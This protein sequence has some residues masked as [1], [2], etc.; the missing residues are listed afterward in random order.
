MTITEGQVT[1][2]TNDLRSVIQGDRELAF[3]YLH[4]Q[5]QYSISA[6][7][8]KAQLL[9]GGRGIGLTAYHF[10]LQSRNL[11]LLIHRWGQSLQHMREPLDALVQRGF[12]ELFASVPDAHPSVLLDALL[13]ASGQDSQ[14]VPK[15]HSL[16]AIL[17]EH[18]ES[19]QKV[20]IGLV[21][22]GNTDEAPKSALLSHFTEEVTSR[23][24]LITDFL[25]REIPVHLSVLSAVDR[26]Q[27]MTKTPPSQRYEL[28]MSR[29][30][31]WGTD[32]D[33][34]MHIG[35]VRL[36]DLGRMYKDLG[37]AFFE[38]NVRAGLAEDEAPNRAIT[39]A[40]RSIIVDQKTDPRV[41]AFNHNGVTLSVESLKPIENGFEIVNPRLL[42][43]AQTVSTFGRF[44]EKAGV[45]LSNAQLTD[46][47]VLAKII[48]SPDDRFTA[49]VTINNNRQNPVMPWDLRANDPIQLAIQDWLRDTLG[50][51]YERQANSFEG[52]S[53]LSDEQRGSLGIIASKPISL[54]KLAS[55][56]LAVDGRVDKMGR[57]KEVF[58]DDSIYL[59]VFRPDRLE[60]DARAVVYCYKI[61]KCIAKLLKQLNPDG[62][63][64]RYAFLYRGRNLVWALL[65]QAFLN[66]TKNLADNMAFYGDELVI[67]K[68]L[69]DKLARLAKDKV[70]PILDRLVDQDGYRELMKQER[71]GFLTTR[72]TF[73]R[74]MTIAADLWE[75]K[76]RSLPKYQSE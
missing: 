26:K 7:M 16:R 6:E 21:F 45:R 75:W 57:M 63:E 38:S 42:N 29:S 31:D 44:I 28:A 5:A 19:I 41:F 9:V 8:A 73:D 54:V 68:S 40:L 60:T 13:F 65:C 10:D 33:I 50:I 15:L 4:L 27:Y 20:I 14:L 3:A 69:R 66:D 52:L 48:V 36:A 49:Q 53:R 67:P 62:V 71:Y 37:I 34:S 58:E 35:F 22:N 1:Q 76:R 46:L 30:L 2:A 25:A 59:D 12:N 55:T 56:F 17:T 74:A 18:Q 61:D 70:R 24:H 43:G 32:P 47:K 11:Y 23:K 72:A 64:G 39:A 51:Y